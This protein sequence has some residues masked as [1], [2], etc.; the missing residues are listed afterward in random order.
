[1]RPPLK[2]L[3]ATLVILVA[4]PFASMGRSDESELVVESG[5]GQ[6]AGFRWDALELR[7]RAGPS[8]ESRWEARIDGIE[9]PAGS[10]F[11][12]LSVVCRS[13][14]AT[15]SDGCG[16][17]AVDWANGDDRV[18][19][20]LGVSVETAGDGRRLTIQGD[21]WA[22]EA[23]SPGS[24][25]EAWRIDLVLQGADLKEFDAPL[26]GLFGLAYFD[27]ELEGT[28]TLDP[29]RLVAELEISNLAFDTPDGLV[30]GAGL[31]LS[32]SLDAD[33]S[34]EAIPFD[35]RLRQLGGEVLAGAVY[36]PSP[37]QPLSLAVA[38]RRSEPGELVIDGFSLR[39]PEALK[40]EGQAR[41]RE[42]ASGW[43]IDALNPAQ[44]R[45]EL[46]RG[47]NRWLEGWAGAAGFPGLETE[48]SV[49]AEIEF[50]SSRPPR[51][52]ARLQSLSI[53]DPAGRLALQDME[54]EVTWDADGPGA[55]LNWQGLTVY[56]L[57]LREASLRLASDER[58][59]RLIEPLRL[60]LLDGAL[61][62]D[63]LRQPDAPESSALVE[64]DARIEPISL[65]PLTRQL[66][67]PEFGGQLSGRFPG[68]RL[69]ADRI[70]FTGG[71]D[72]NA[73]SGTI[74]LAD[75]VIER[76]FGTLPAL[77]TDVTLTRL[78]LLQLTGAFNFGRMEGLASGWMRGLRL[79]D[80]RPVAM[81]ARVF[82]HDDAPRRRISQRAVDNLSSLGG[83][84]GAL[85]TGTVLSVFEDFPY[86]R[87]GLACRL[88]N[89][90]CHVDG[91][92]PHESGGFY[93]VEGRGLP[94][95]DVIGHRRLVD[96]PLMLRQLEALGQ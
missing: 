83:A 60:P 92:A 91:V 46:P 20:D 51:A 11:G 5:P 52:S 81:D 59:P 16:S 65:A 18:A 87:A 73:F 61:V 82:T 71:I 10:P 39:D 41:L 86:R 31:A 7:Y 90:I 95:L 54:G 42:T 12:S 78:D 40:V 58:G 45:L 94:R 19:M 49:S 30:A 22:L 36:L 4:L 15:P 76:P 85:M 68:L 3:F 89:N 13:A 62:L 84:G 1:M 79:L 26:A 67:W 27:A 64:L 77:A 24:G 93:I 66:G 23:L 53:L 14:E 75:L 6:I 33:L 50:D 47:W 35:L 72:I 28:V 21:R 74:R 70:D 63:G 2:S 44:V 55:D 34:Q 48:G 32:V 80:W 37:Q 17:A 8:P 38:G 43:E 56:D 9:T 25:S 96:W 29:Q 69:A 88:T 57:P